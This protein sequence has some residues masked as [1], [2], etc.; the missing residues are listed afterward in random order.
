MRFGSVSVVIPAFNAEATIAR[1]VASAWSQTRRPDEVIV[2][3]DGSS[4]GTALAAESAGATVLRLPHANGA[5]A[6]NR[7]VDAARGEL[8]FFL[9]ADDVWTPHKVSAHL[10]TWAAHEVSFVYDV[11]TQ[12]RPDGTRAGLMGAGGEGPVPWES[13][14]QWTT[15]ASGSSFSVA[16]ER[17]IAV[18]GFREELV[19]QQDVDFWVRVASEFG[20]AWRVS[21]SHTLYQLSPGGVSK[22]PFAV[23]KNLETLLAGWPF[24]SDQQKREFFVLMALTAAGFTPFPR[25]LEYLGLAGWPV[26]RPKFWRAIARSIRDAA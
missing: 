11:A 20:P 21:A 4:D 2:A 26:L 12:V 17:S 23:S 15:W 9:D 22:T 6:R 25:C 3:D 8:L 18:G 24:A 1:A 13:F 10:D 16:Q 7:G 5:V 14:L 19:S